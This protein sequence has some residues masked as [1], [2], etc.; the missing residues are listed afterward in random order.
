MQR[1]RCSHYG[2]LSI[3]RRDNPVCVS[4]GATRCKHRAKSF[5]CRLLLD[6]QPCN[7]CRS[8]VSGLTITIYTLITISI[9]GGD[10]V[11]LLPV[12]GYVVFM[13]KARIHALR[14]CV[15]PSA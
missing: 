5:T 13:P 14:R 9:S 1:G 3:W 12:T 15:L 11:Q 10:F 8:T 4:K 6:Y 7:S 2:G